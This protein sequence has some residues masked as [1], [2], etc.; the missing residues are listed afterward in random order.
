M[1]LPGLRLRL[2]VA[3][4]LAVAALGPLARASEPTAQWQ[5]TALLDGKPIGTHHYG[6]TVGDG[7]MRRLVSEARFDVR[8]LGVAVYRYR[9]RVDERWRGDCLTSIDASTDDDGRT[10]SVSG[11]ATGAGFAIE[12]RGGPAP[13]A[14]TVAGCLMSYAYWSP[15]LANRR[16]LLDPGTGRIDAVSVTPLPETTLEVRGRPVPVRGWRI[17]GPSQP[18]DVWYSGERWVGLDTTV[19]GGRQLSYRLQ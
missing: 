16:Q 3:C 14:V 12:A 11:S 4:G 15:G 6:L 2:V 9:H 17:Q 8:L 1:P 10:S 19:A 18:I 5:F 13:G 7:G